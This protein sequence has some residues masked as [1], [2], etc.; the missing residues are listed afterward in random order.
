MWDEPP[1]GA[2]TREV[3]LDRCIDGS[4]LVCSNLEHQATIAWNGRT[5]KAPV[6][7][8]FKAG[9]SLSKFQRELIVPA[10]FCRVFF[11]FTKRSHF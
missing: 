3:H 4:P 5:I 6:P 1:N 8:G 7:K 9:F 10:E 2:R 11:S